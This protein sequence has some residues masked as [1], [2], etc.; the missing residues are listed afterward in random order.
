MYI[1]PSWACPSYCVAVA[2]FLGALLHPVAA[3]QPIM[4]MMPRWDDGYGVQAILEQRERDELFDGEDLVGDFDEDITILHLE[5]VYTWTRS[6]RAT[7]KVPIVLDAERELPG[8]ENGEG[9][10][11]RQTDSGVGDATVALPLKKYINED[12]ASG[13]WSFVPQIRVPLDAEDDDF[14]VYDGAWGTGLFLGW[15]R[16]TYRTF[17]STGVSGWSFFGDEP[18][19]FHVNLDLGLNFADRGQVLME[20]D[21]HAESDGTRVL[22]TGPAL[23]W[24]FSDLIHGRLEWKESV[25]DDHGDES[26]DHGGG[27][28]LSVGLGFVH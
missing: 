1:K 6:I 4:N 20:T 16:E 25:Y 14:E 23:Y 21:F 7:V 17:V 18:N 28:T 9:E 3:D 10:T 26:L 24:R 12:G 15:E 19:E 11:V 5:G 22:M 8:D 13:S 2:L 27:R